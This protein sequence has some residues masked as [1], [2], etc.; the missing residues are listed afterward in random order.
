MEVLSCFLQ[1]VVKEGQ[2]IKGF[3][4]V[5][6][7]GCGLGSRLLV[8]DDNFAFMWGGY[9]ASILC[10]VNSFMFWD[11]FGIQN[12]LREKWY[13]A[14][15]KD[16]EV[17]VCELGCTRRNLPS[18]YMGYHIGCSNQV[19]ISVGFSNERFMR[20]LASWKSQSLSEG[21]TLTLLKSTLSTL[22]IIYYWLL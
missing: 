10:K 1:R 22:L 12:Q 15:K 4:V 21:G 5:E 6:C 17:L 14:C 3:K 2:L 13:L 9:K 18:K 20:R 7:K 19:L 11:C 8:A 16:L